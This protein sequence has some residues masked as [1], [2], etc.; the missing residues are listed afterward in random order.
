MVTVN[1]TVGK[2]LV[3]A[4][5]GEPGLAIVDIDFVTDRPSS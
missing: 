5:V 1:R 3:E 4:V 2:A